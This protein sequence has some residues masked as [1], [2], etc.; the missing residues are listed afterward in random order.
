METEVSFRGKVK[1]FFSFGK[2]SLSA[3]SDEP[4]LKADFTAGN[5][6]SFFAWSYTG[7]KNLG[8]IGPVK[9]YKPSYQ[10]LR[11]RS[12]QSYL[13]SEISQTV[14][15]RFITWVIGT[16]LKLQSE[17]ARKVLESENIK[18][19]THLFSEQV[20]SRFNVYR[21]S[22]RSDFTEMG[23]LDFIAQA[24]YKNAIIGGDVL[25][26]LRYA[27]N[28]V[29]VQLIDG[30]HVQ[31]PL[32]GSEALP[33]PL[34][35]GNRVINGIEQTPA[36]KHVRYFVKG[37]NNQFQPIECRGKE[38]GMQMAFM[39][40]GLK[41]RLDNNRGIPLIAVVLETLKKLERYKEATVGSA[42]E[43]QKIAFAIEHGIGSTGENPLVAQMAKAFNSDTNTDEIAHDINGQALAD[44][45][46]ATT[47][48]QAINL[49]INAT[50]KILESKNELYF[51]EFYSVNI[52]CI[53]A[54]LGIPPEVAMS[55]Y[56]SNFSASRAAL[57]DWENTLIVARHGFAFQFYQKV[58][59]FW[60]ETEILK[61]KINA[62]GYLTAKLKGEHVVLDSFRMARFVGPPVPHIDPLKEVK[63]EREKLG[64]AG[65]HIP[66]TTAEASTEALNGGEASAN[67]SQFAA[68]L[69]QAETLKITAPV[70]Q[71]A[72]AGKPDDEEDVKE[73]VGKKK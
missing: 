37:A 57:K 56:D 53:C 26:V 18:F 47:N 11:L 44:K 4:E 3:E 70:V 67:M 64:S 59:N 51:K 41:Y 63:A 68:E 27:N 72:V 34:P 40:Y 17:P 29:N 43:R 46:A 65:A 31:S 24:A 39:V 32:T 15:N 20:E 13:D 22:E 1:N 35:N 52:D 14:M 5:Y 30:A 58:Y 38:S 48:K 71:P 23:N 8:E 33:L 42:E 45:V 49:P 6:N 28:S 2:K 10:I 55:K 25:V 69:K 66:L 62:P 36:G 61:N 73:D 21:K 7:E 60:L 16:G 54:C 19:D 50:L 9:D 12:W